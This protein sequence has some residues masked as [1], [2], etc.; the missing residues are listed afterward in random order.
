MSAV[1]NT[2]KINYTV[3]PIPGGGNEVKS[4]LFRVAYAAY[5]PNMTSSNVRVRNAT[6]DNNTMEGV[7]CLT[8]I[9]ANTSYLVIYQF[10]YSVEVEA[11][12]STLL[13]SDV[14]TVE[15]NTGRTCNSQ[16]CLEV[17][18]TK[19]ATLEPSTTSYT[20][21]PSTTLS[22]SQPSSMG[23][24]IPSTFSPKETSTTSS[25]P[26]TSIPSS[27]TRPGPLQTPYGE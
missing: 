3:S 5:Q 26:Q 19:T 25:P 10:I 21:L 12:I 22:S 6:L 20:I 24:A 18:R 13:P 23:D 15:V 17:S 1:C 16:Q 7:L 9:T 8:N 27:T 2:L 11:D 14:S 4:T